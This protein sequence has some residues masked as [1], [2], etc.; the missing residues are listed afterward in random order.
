MAGTVESA[1]RVLIIVENLPVPF[2]R[3]VWQEAK[4]LKEAGY[5]VSVICPKGR[6]HTASYEQIDGIH[7]YRHW[8]PLDAKG[9]FG[10]LLEYSAA[11]FA[12]FF[13]SIRVLRRHGFDIIHACNPPD[14]I[15]L[16]AAF[17]KAF[18]RKKFIFDQHDLSPELFEVKFGRKGL[19]HRLLVIF[20]KWTFSL[21]D[22]SLAT[23]ETFRDLAIS[24]A[25]MPAKRVFIVKSYPDL[26]R[27][28]RIEPDSTARS[29]FQYLVGYVG[30]IAAQD[31]VDLLVKAMAFIANQLQRKD[32]GCVIIGDGPQLADLQQLVQRLGIAGQ[33]QFS[34]YLSGN[35]LLAK[36]SAC[37]VG[38]IPDPPNVFNDK[39][40]MNKVFEYMAM[41]LPVVQFDL[42]Q[43]RHEAGSAAEIVET[44]TPEALGA[45]IVALLANQSKR[46]AMSRYGR[47]RAERE[48]Q[49][50]FAERSLLAAYQAAFQA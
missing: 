17:H 31:G 30:V 5:G 19:L 25:G 3:R 13:L 14:L 26:A 48:F 46:D 50:Q 4:A 11:L 33:V 16:V 6:G 8:L 47:E 24:R 29:G 27:F 15:F 9:K 18:F 1:K 41:G 10:F 34:G 23:N 22:V 21:A 2:D 36:L 40:S 28:R 7:I 35:Q 43:A 38:V 37:D 32:I 20:E 42:A 12:E 45:K 44:P 39:V 49:W